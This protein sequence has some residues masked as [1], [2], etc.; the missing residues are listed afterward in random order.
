MDDEL[1]Q[2]TE[3]GCI[4]GTL[5]WGSFTCIALALGLYL[6]PVSH[7]V[8]AANQLS[9]RPAVVETVRR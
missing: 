2:F 6:W 5:I 7:E 9:A 1:E 4:R 3:L 8:P